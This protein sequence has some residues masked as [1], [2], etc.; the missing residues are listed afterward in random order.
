MAI[1]PTISVPYSISISPAIDKI[2]DKIPPIFSSDIIAPED[3]KIPEIPADSD[4]NSERVPFQIDVEYI[5]PDNAS[6]DVK[7][8][9]SVLLAVIAP[10]IDEI[11]CSSKVILALKSAIQVVDPA[12]PEVSTKLAFNID[13]ELIAPDIDS[14]ALIAALINDVV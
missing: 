11:P 1:E 7:P 12:I 2:D 10:V 3:S 14:I 6:P 4:C 9:L 8:P 13:T 5:K